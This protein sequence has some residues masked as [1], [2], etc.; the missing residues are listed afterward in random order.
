MPVN[1]PLCLMY[2]VTSGICSSR[3]AVQIDCFDQTTPLKIFAFTTQAIEG[4]ALS[5]AVVG[6]EVTLHCQLYKSGGR[7]ETQGPYWNCVPFGTVIV[8]EDTDS[9]TI[10]LLFMAF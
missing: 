6:L 8:E 5:M 4:K 9:C 10:W 7:C 1:M 2:F 3:I